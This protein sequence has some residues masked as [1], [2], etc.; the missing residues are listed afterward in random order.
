[1]ALRVTL[2]IRIER[3]SMGSFYVNFAVPQ[4]TSEATA[5][6]LKAMG[7]KA[8]VAPVTDG[9]VYFY[10]E[11]ADAQDAAQIM[12]LGIAASQSLKA[13]VLAVMNHDDDILQYWLFENG[14]VVDTYNSSPGYFDDTIDDLPVG[15]DAAALVRAMGAVADPAALEAILRADHESDDYAFAM[16][17]HL[18]LAEILKLPEDLAVLGYGY[19]SADTEGEEVPERDAFIKV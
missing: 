15:G 12:E 7:R 3:C 5:A 16:D 10:D 9:F 8:F 14:A 6:A 18:A 19:I 1:M 11:A 2:V 4:Q 13:P 17:R